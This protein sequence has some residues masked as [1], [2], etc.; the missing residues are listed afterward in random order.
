MARIAFISLHTSPLDSP[1]SKDA[2]GMNVVEV[3]QAIALGRLGHT[4]E[5]VTRRDSPEWPETTKIAPGVTVRYLTAGPAEP[6]AKSA[7][8]EWIDEFSAALATLEPYDLVHSQHWMSGVAALPV[9]R[10]WGVPHVQSF[11]SVAA[12]PGDPLG[13]GEPPES[14]GRNAGERLIAQGSDASVAVSE[15]E[16]RTIVERC[17][18]DPSR[19]RVVHPG[20]DV[21]LFHPACDDDRRWAPELNQDGEPRQYGPVCVAPNPNGYVLFA[22]RLQ[23]LKAPDLA[24]VAVAGIPADIRP[25]LVIAGEASQDFAGYRDELVDLSHSLGTADQ[26]CWLGSQS[27]DDLARLFRGARMVLVPSFSETFGLVALEAQASGVPVVAADSGGLREAVVDGETG[28]VLASRDA[29]DWTATL[30]D[31][32]RHPDRLEAMGAAGRRRAEGFTWNI[33]GQQLDA[34]Y[35]ELR[36][37][38]VSST[39]P[40]TDI[41]VAPAGSPG[42]VV[43][44][45]ETTSLLD[46]VGRILFA[47][48]HPD[49]ET[50]AT[51]ALITECVRR[52]IACDVATATRGEMGEVVPGP[53]SHLFGTPELEAHRAGE[54]AGALATLGVD[55]HAFLGADP[56]RAEG[57][58]PRRYRDSGMEWI[59]PG[60]A[61]P[62]DASDER[63]LT[64]GSV[65]DEAADL[66]AL[67]RAWQPD[68]LVTYDAGG[69]YGHPDHVRMH[70]VTRRVSGITGVP[71]L[72]VRNTPGEGVEWLDLADTLPVVAE[73]LRSHQSQ[74]TVQ[75]NGT[76]VVHSGGQREA[77][78]TAVGLSR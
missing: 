33:A 25:T 4:V 48:A 16:A 74:L 78:V 51:G 50:L 42:P 77:I 69:G 41:P 17:G 56:A 40:G 52:G 72:E 27:R 53:L 32:L 9:A 71:M 65:D 43:E 57:L 34:I 39:S 46:G 54:L 49:D 59:R 18:A 55:R 38:D 20:V 47:H 10:R 14:P 60:L 28:I 76:E 30:T 62:A 31:L 63:S 68:V 24:Q 37:G 70:D 75:P 11:H 64:A 61:G 1:G 19:V 58:E 67:V 21:E 12:L 2:G 35:R 8:E 5:L 15:Y 6:L 66:A 23:P 3:N 13:Q 45:V 29:A 26:T 7:Q 36:S 73:A 44:P 22:A